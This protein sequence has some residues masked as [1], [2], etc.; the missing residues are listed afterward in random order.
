[1]QTRPN[2]PDLNTPDPLYMRRLLPAGL[3][4][5]GMSV[6]VRLAVKTGNIFPP[7]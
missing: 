5:A 7:A 6:T 3:R 1:M 2:Q 4:S